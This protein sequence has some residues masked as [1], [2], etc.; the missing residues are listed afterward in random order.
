MTKGQPA[1]DAWQLSPETLDFISPERRRE[2]EEH[3]RE[4]EELL[5]SAERHLAE[6]K[7]LRESARR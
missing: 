5:E 6:A 7:R 1:D 2:F 3:D 4:C